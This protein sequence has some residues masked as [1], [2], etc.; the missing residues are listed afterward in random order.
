MLDLPFA[1]LASYLES[2][3]TWIQGVAPLL[4]DLYVI[5]CEAAWR[6]AFALGIILV[7]S[8]L[9]GVMAQ[10]RY[11]QRRKKWAESIRPGKGMGI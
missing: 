5:C 10:A 4:F 6:L 11:N 7:V 3:W 9:G 2:A 1:L 8:L